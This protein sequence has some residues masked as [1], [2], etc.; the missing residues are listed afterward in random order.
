MS[1]LEDRNMFFSKTWRVH[2]MIQSYISGN[3][4]IQK[5]PENANY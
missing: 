5:P 3:L 4:T 2:K 1:H